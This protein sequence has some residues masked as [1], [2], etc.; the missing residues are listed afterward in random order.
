[1][2]EEDGNM[3]D[4]ARNVEVIFKPGRIPGKDRRPGVRNR[5]I[6]DSYWQWWT[7]AAC[8]EPG[9]TLLDITRR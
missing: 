4:K 8:G 1:M 2:A 3:Q 6:A 5:R 7:L 9:V